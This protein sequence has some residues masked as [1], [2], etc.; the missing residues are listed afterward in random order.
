[1]RRW[2][3][4]GDDQFSLELPEQGQAFL[5]DRVGGGSPLADITLDAACE[6]V[7]GYLW[8]IAGVH[9][10]LGAAGRY[11]LHSHKIMV[12]LGIRLRAIVVILHSY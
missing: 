1:M 8:W 12:H 6:Q 7:P 3:G 11:P 2:N 10:P 9:V 5:A 4:W